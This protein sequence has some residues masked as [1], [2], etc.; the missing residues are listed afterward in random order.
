MSIGKLS[1]SKENTAVIE[2]PFKPKLDTEIVRPPS[3]A[4][5]EVPFKPLLHPEDGLYK[6]ITGS[7]V[8]V[9][10]RPYLGN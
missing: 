1:V 10:F 9:P 3:T 7:E 2:V 5:I 6:P 4:V 8:E